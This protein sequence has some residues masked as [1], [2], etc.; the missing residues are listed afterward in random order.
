MPASP[1]T[2]VKTNNLLLE[3][4]LDIRKDIVI[5]GEFS[6]FGS[7]VNG[8]EGFSVYFINACQNND[9]G[10][11]GPGLG[12]APTDGL[13][14]FNG[15]D[16]F[17]GIPDSVFGV[18][19]DIAGSF[20][21]PL[22]PDIDGDSVAHPNSI[23]LRHGS[24]NNYS[25]ISSSE[26]VTSLGV[27]IY[28]TYGDSYPIATPTPS[29]TSTQTPTKTFTNT[30]NTTATATSTPTRT[31][32]ITST[33]TSTI[34]R[35]K[36]QSP[37]FTQTKTVCVTATKTPTRTHSPTFTLTNSVSKTTTKTQTGLFPI[38]QSFKIRLSDYGRTVYVYLKNSAGKFILVHEENHL[39]L[40]KPEN[41]QVQIGLSYSTGV[42]HSA[43][44]LYNFNVNGVGY[45]SPFTP[46]PTAT[47]NITRTS[48]PTPTPTYTVTYTPTINHSATPTQ[49]RTPTNTRTLTQTSTNFATP[50]TTCTQTPTQ[51]RTA[52]NTRT[53]TQ[54]ATRTQTPTN[55]R[56]STQTPTNTST[57]TPT[58]T[59]TRTPTQTRTV[60]STEQVKFI[61][62]QNATNKFVIESNWIQAESAAAAVNVLINNAR[63][64]INQNNTPVNLINVISDD[65]PDGVVDPAVS[66]NRTNVRAFF[67]DGPA[68]AAQQQAPGAD[69]VSDWVGIPFIQ[70]KLNVSNPDINF[71]L[72]ISSNIYQAL[73]L[74][75]NVGNTLDT[76]LINIDKKDRDNFDIWNYQGLSV[77]YKTPV[78]DLTTSNLYVRNFNNTAGIVYNFDYVGASRNDFINTP[79][80]YR[81]QPDNRFIQIADQE[82]N[83]TFSYSTELI[84]YFSTST[85]SSYWGARLTLFTNVRQ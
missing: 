57:Q 52:T 13:V 49:T 44:Y 4:I 76:T 25:Y 74:M 59:A 42:N 80:S 32:T 64:F 66:F 73:R 84:N 38:R 18:G 19:F 75:F 62:S 82:T 50:T 55:T 3:D 7:S 22:G 56:T 1:I 51:S 31:S 46:T 83:I 39:D 24:V 81:I 9:V 2:N 30:N 16:I 47:K 79:D 53:S 60:S 72:G 33:R 68:G 54:F 45:D 85:Q 17:S 20:A 43:F 63:F 41:G 71:K 37:T 5:S 6:L 67:Y 8:G 34:S 35:T 36:T 29:R 58:N 69:G 77:D 70:N 21:L 27:K 15:T 28:E 14:E 10:S 40:I 12:F 23:T 48:S 78:L 11:P 26:D 65:N 61:A